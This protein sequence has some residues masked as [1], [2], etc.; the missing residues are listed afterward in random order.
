M[1]FAPLLV[2][3]EGN[4]NIFRLQIRDELEVICHGFL[5]NRPVCRQRI[6][7]SCNRRTEKLHCNGN[8]ASRNN[9]NNNNDKQTFN[10]LH[11]CYHDKDADTYKSAKPSQHSLCSPTSFS[12]DVLFEMSGGLHSQRKIMCKNQSRQLIIPL[13]FFEDSYSFQRSSC[14]GGPGF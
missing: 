6:W 4:Y 14:W 8:P 11:L 3:H 13:S 2:I 12:G 1:C 5:L 9:N 7:R 10:L